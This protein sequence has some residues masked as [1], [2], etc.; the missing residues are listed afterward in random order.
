M[1]KY[2]MQKSDLVGG[3]REDFAEQMASD[4]ISKGW[5]GVIKEGKKWKRQEKHSKLEHSI[6]QSSLVVVPCV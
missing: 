6:C 2:I 1:Q 4:L 3:V 5:I